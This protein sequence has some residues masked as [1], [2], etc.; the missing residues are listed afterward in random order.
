MPEM[1][2]QGVK[3]GSVALADE[4]GEG[5][6]ALWSGARDGDPCAPARR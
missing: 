1:M 2:L 5:L 6:A 4:S 3:A